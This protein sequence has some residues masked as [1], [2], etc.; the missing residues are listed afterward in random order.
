[1][2]LLPPSFQELAERITRRE[3]R[4][5]AKEAASNLTAQDI[6]RRF[7]EEIPELAR[8]LELPYTYLVNWSLEELVS[9]LA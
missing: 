8:S 2:Y 5:E 4:C 3:S 9:V 1:M 6:E 7:Y